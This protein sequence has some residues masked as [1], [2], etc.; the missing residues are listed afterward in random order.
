MAFPPGSRQPWTGISFLHRNPQADLA[1]RSLPQAAL[2]G[3]VSTGKH[4]SR[5]GSGELA[6]NKRNKEGRWACCHL[7]GRMRLTWET[8]ICQKHGLCPKEV[9]R[10]PLGRI[11]PH[12]HS[13]FWVPMLTLPSIRQTFSEPRRPAAVL[14]LPESQQTGAPRRNT[15]KAEHMRGACEPCGVWRTP[16]GSE[17]QTGETGCLSARGGVGARKRRNIF[18]RFPCPGA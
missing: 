11:P 8:P 13:A 6:Q 2:L 3:F 14:S 7:P 10:P 17:S 1:T 18:H 12:T 16:P 15:Q 5:F 9:L 4:T